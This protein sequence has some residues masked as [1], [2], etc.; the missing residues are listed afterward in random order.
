MKSTKTVLRE[1]KTVDMAT[2]EVV[3]EKHTLQYKKEPAFVKLY[4][5]CLG[6]FIDN[7]G[8]TKSLNDM[9]IEVL[10]NVTYASDD[11]I[12]ILNA[13]TKERICKATKK[14]QIRLEKAITTWVDN[15]VLIR[16]GRGVYRL[17]PFIFGKGEWRDIEN[18]RAKFDYKNGTVTT[19]IDHSTETPSNA[20]ESPTSPVEE[21]T[22]TDTPP[23]VAFPL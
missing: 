5:D 22:G 12:V 3:R 23:K 15:R 8:M 7:S 16:V 17:N 1:E 13:Y 20:P 18:L 19:E 9:L 6:V 21:A 4:L 10:K 11:Q 2:G 14:S